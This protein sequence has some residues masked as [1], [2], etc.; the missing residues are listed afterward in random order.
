MHKRLNRLLNFAKTTAIGG[1]IFLLP[2][3]VIGVLVGQVV[4]LVIWIAGLIHEYSPLK[5]AQAYAIAVVAALA[6]V[7]A[8]SFAA[9]LVAQRSIGQQFSSWVEKNLTLLFPRYAIFKQQLA[10]NLGGGRPEELPKSVLVRVQDATWLGLEMERSE[11][12]W[13]TVYRP[14]SPDPWTGSVVLLRAEQVEPIDAEF[15]RLLTCYEQLGR[16]SL[17]VAFPAAAPPPSGE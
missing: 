2:L 7:V 5:S 3:I 11:E 9:G 6:I 1:V 8:L 12:G 15:L 10:G 16:G 17:G 14:S 13:V 4:P